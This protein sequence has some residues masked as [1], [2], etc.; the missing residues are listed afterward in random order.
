VIVRISAFRRGGRAGGW[1]LAASAIWLALAASWWIGG[2]SS[3]VSLWAFAASVLLLPGVP[4]VLTLSAVVVARPSW[5]L[6]TALAWLGAIVLVPGF[7]VVIESWG[8]VDLY[9]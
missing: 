7:V 3:P 9:C 6:V 8:G 5:T 1:T 4:G 2:R